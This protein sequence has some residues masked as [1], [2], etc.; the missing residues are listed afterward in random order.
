[1]A[2][3]IRRTQ[4]EIV[5][6]EPPSPYSIERFDDTDNETWYRLLKNKKPVY[7]NNTSSSYKCYASL[8]RIYEVMN[9]IEK[10]EGYKITKRV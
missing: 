7:I 9:E 1:M 2:Y 3:Y 10:L 8:E 6:G 4:E 5:P